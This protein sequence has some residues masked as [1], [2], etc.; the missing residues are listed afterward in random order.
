MKVGST[1]SGKEL[2]IP[3]SEFTTAGTAILAMRGG[4][5][6]WLAGVLI[7]QLAR[8]GIPFVVVDP[9][10][11]YW[12]LRV[13]FSNV[14]IAGG[15][16]A[17]I[18][19]EQPLAEILGQTAVEERLQMVLD[20]SDM[21]RE[22]QRAFLS[23]F[24]TELFVK[25]TE[26]RIPLWICFEEADLW[27]PQ[28]GKPSSKVPVLDICQRGRKRGLGFALVSQRPATI[29]KTALSQAEFRFFKR[30][31]QPHDLRAVEDY[32]AAYA[33]QAD[34]LPALS[35]K[36]TL[37]YAPTVSETPVRLKV[38][39]RV[40]PHGGATPEQIQEIERSTTTLELK[41][42]IEKILGD[43]KRKLNEIEKRDN[44]IQ[45]LR[46]KIERLEE[47]LE[48]AKIA[49][50]VAEMLTESG[51]VQSR[52]KQ[53]ERDFAFNQDSSETRLVPSDED[54]D[55]AILK[56]ESVVYL[57]KV[58][59]DSKTGQVIGSK[60]ADLLLNR[61]EPDERVVFLTLKSKNGPSSATAISR[62]ISFSP[63]KTRRIFK[64][65]S[66]KGLL[67]KK[68]RD[69]RGVLYATI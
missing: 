2:D 32:L 51:L 49:N 46:T 21:R 57:G 41:E 20:L 11:E 55:S 18:P 67:R 13:E 6:S 1:L 39:G 15:E 10:G 27:V 65:L 28:S 8:E 26:L 61:M 14:V 29:D 45:Q 3:F 22:E 63:R 42:K 5:K 52:E 23:R 38:P 48:K 58:G 68:G 34:T 62:D 43:E 35:V 16:H 37:L 60:S 59:M 4:G 64:Q 36:E 47:K 30:F 66:R 50:D 7:E 31:Q 19:L 54:I 69:R 56:G 9:E 44:I 12:T 40:C 33:D 53:K 25:E 24:L 17:D